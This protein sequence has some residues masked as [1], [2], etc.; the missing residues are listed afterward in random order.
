MK[1]FA[2]AA[3]VFG[4]VVLARAD[5]APPMDHQPKGV[6]KVVQWAIDPFD[7][8]Q[9]WSLSNE[10]LQFNSGLKSGQQWS[11]KFTKRTYKRVRGTEPGNLEFIRILPSKK[12]RGNLFLMV[13]TE[14]GRSQIFF[15]SDFGENWSYL[16]TRDRS[17]KGSD[18]SVSSASGDGAVD[19]N[20]LNT[21]PAPTSAGGGGAP[22]EGANGPQFKAYFD[23]LLTNRPGIS[24]LTFDNYHTFFLVDFIPKPG[25]QFSFE[26]SPTPRFF[27]LDYDITDRFGFYVGRIMVPFDD[28]NPHNRFGGYINNS[29][30]AQPGAPAFLPDI[31][32]DLG[33]GIRYKLLD[34]SNLTVLTHL[35][36]VNGFQEGGNDPVTVGSPYPNFGALPAPDN[37]AD[38][39]LGVRFQTDFFQMVSFIFSFQTGNYANAGRPSSRMTV[40]GAGARIRPNS[41]T[42]IRVGYVYFTVDL[43]LGSALSSFQRGGLYGEF[44]QK[45]G[46]FYAAVEAGVLQTDDRVSDGGDQ[47]MVGGRLGY[48]T[49][50]FDLSLQY[51]HDMKDSAAKINRD[52]TALRFAISL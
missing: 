10:S 18:M 36:L 52:F 38:K 7:S 23:V 24:P 32:A 33:V 16:G 3:L 43:P 21:S 47:T 6:T 28:M 20:A 8:N 49:A 14:S 15:T 51:R 30:T 50:M 48:Q 27:Q 26:L 22:S 19:L 25:I 35:Y 46:S 31:W 11:V 37:N 29:K 17:A 34:L 12:K 13:A 1:L 4:L 41:T 44:R 9:G 42:Q 39:T 5:D 45:F 2:A 40:L